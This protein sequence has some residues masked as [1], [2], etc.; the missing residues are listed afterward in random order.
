MSDYTEEQWQEAIDFINQEFG[1][2]T[3]TLTKAKDLLGQ[4]TS[5][6]ESLESQVRLKSIGLALKMA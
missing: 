2:D 4:V 1:S 5:T 3:K 6:K